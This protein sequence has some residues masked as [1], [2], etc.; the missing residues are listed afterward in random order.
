MTSFLSANDLYKN[1]KFEEAI[2]VYHKIESQ[3]LESSELYYNLGNSYYKLNKVGPSIYYYEKSLNKTLN[4]SSL[5]VKLNKYIDFDYQPLIFGALYITQPKPTYFKNYFENDSIND[6]FHKDFDNK[7]K[8]LV[9]MINNKMDVD[10]D[11]LTRSE[12]LKKL[13]IEDSIKWVI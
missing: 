13:E 5:Y 4:K 7:W 11:Q 8:Q 6:H 1:N 12:M 2:N 3:G 9:D 10:E